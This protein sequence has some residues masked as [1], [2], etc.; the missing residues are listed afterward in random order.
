MAE[1][2]VADNDEIIVRK[3]Q[4]AERFF[5]ITNESF[6][7]EYDTVVIKYEVTGDI[8]AAKQFIQEKYA[9]LVGS[10]T[11]KEKP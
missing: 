7:I 1:N 10:F 2:I 5:S 4:D 8:I 3:V 11:L 9:G 6:V